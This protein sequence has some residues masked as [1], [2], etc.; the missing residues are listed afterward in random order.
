[1]H[2]TDQIL[3]QE[4]HWAS[5]FQLAVLPFIDVCKK[6]ALIHL[7]MHICTAV[8]HTFQ[9]KLTISINIP[10]DCPKNDD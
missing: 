4:S 9:K 3:N 5:R 8:S 2:M 6:F 1:M 7:S 10:K